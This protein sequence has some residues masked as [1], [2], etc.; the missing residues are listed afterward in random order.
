MGLG[1]TGPISQALLHD[2]AP[3]DRIGELLGL[4]VTLLNVSHASVPMLSGALGAA[5]GVGPV[6][7]VVAACLFAGGWM[8]RGQLRP[9][10]T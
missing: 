3:A 9:L 10:E 5:I 6:F 7:W 4:R 1:L 2:L 8:T